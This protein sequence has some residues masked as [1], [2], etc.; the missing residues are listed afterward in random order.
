MK[1]QRLDPA[2]EN[3]N[4]RTGEGSALLDGI[5]SMVQFL[6]RLCR[7]MPQIDRQYTFSLSYHKWHSTEKRTLQKSSWMCPLRNSQCKSG[8]V[9]VTSHLCK[10]FYSL[11]LSHLYILW[12][13]Y[14]GTS[15]R[16]LRNT[17]PL[18]SKFQWSDLSW[19]DDHNSLPKM[20]VH[21][22]MR[23]HIFKNVW[24]YMNICIYIYMILV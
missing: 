21:I 13:L 23:F 2:K 5:S 11:F 6:Y 9:Q 18:Q 17:V 14:S 15:H 19:D 10:F 1:H 8:L 4:W 12:Q 3:W 24:I 16:Q 22:S 20:V 7:L